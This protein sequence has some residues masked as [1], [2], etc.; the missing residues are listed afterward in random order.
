MSKPLEELVVNWGGFEKLVEKIHS[1]G[2]VSV[3]HNVT[4]LGKSGAS[5]QIDV[6]IVHKDELYENLIVAECKYWKTRVTR[7]HVDIVSRTVSE[8]NASKGV[9]FSVK[10]FQKGAIEQAA[11]DGIELYMVREL[12]D[13]EWGLPGKVIDFHIQYIRP[14]IGNFEVSKASTY[15]GFKPSNNQLS[16]YIGGDT[17][18]QTKLTNSKDATL[19][20]MINRTVMEATRKI[21]NNSRF[22]PVQSGEKPIF[23]S[24]INVVIKPEGD[25]Q[26]DH[27]GGIIIISEMQYDLGVEVHMTRFVLDRSEDMVFALALESFVSGTKKLITKSN[28]DTFSHVSDFNVP[29][30]IDS[31]DVLHKD[32]ILQVHLHLNN[33]ID[34]F[35]DIDLGKWT[36]V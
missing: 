31:S 18:S 2:T 12:S 21:V 10:G 15:E 32:S 1:T 6:L 34:Q 7:A 11:A 22:S 24:R 3:K 29:Q 36:K 16:L 33:R 25:L 28:E 30:N 4:L 8:V 19:E 9:I 5:R 13:E 23:K 14:S 17:Q 35:L 20:E 27:A 26:V